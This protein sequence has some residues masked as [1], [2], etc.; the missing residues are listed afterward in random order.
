MSDA[1]TLTEHT[2]DFGVEPTVACDGEE[3]GCTEDDCTL[4]V[5]EEDR[6]FWVAGPDWRDYGDGNWFSKED[7][8]LLILAHNLQALRIPPSMA[9]QMRLEMR[10]M[11]T[12]MREVLTTLTHSGCGDETCACESGTADESFCGPGEAILSLQQALRRGP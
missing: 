8:E 2:Q 6:L 10:G 7:A 1:W 3:P 11:E 12:V 5:A 9:W 4:H